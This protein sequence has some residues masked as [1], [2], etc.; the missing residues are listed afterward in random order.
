[1]PQQ[2]D[3]IRQWAAAGDVEKIGRLLHNRLQEAA[4]KVRPELADYQRRLEALHPAGAR[5]SGSGSTWF[6]LCR[7]RNE[8]VRI[9]QALRPGPDERLAPNVYLV[10]SCS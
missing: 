4:E 9:A 1:M 2:G 3:G 7:D 8:A 6:A 10:R 5:M